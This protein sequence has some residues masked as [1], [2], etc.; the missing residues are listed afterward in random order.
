METNGDGLQAQLLARVVE[1]EG[2]FSLHMRREHVPIAE[3]LAEIERTSCALTNALE[4]AADMIAE[5]QERLVLLQ[6]LV[7]STGE[8]GRT[9]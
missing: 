3:R 8:E 1:L 5:H 2:A 9:T 4:A 7:P 6:G